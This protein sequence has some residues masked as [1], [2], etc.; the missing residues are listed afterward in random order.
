MQ[1]CETQIKN[2]ILRFRYGDLILFFYLTFVP[3]TIFYLK[4]N[5]IRIRDRDHDSDH[6]SNCV[7]ARD[8][9]LDLDLD[10]VRAQDNV[11]QRDCLL[12]RVLVCERNR[13]SLRYQLCSSV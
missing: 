7:F 5:S 3:D 6:D 2:T 12:D 10:L 11:S 4:I 1:I 13:Y 8:H 9:D